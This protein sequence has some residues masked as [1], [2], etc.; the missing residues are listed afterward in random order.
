MQQDVIISFANLE[1]SLKEVYIFGN[2][3]ITKLLN[4]N[5]KT[6]CE[7]NDIPNKLRNDSLWHAAIFDKMK[8][9]LH[10]WNESRQ[11]WM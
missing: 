4:Y 2:H 1:V 3:L 11:I 9:V 8:N 5:L 10:I 6:Y 7:I